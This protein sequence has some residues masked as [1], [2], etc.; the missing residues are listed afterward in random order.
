MKSIV[1][2]LSLCLYNYSGLTQTYDFVCGDVGYETDSGGG[3]FLNVEESGVDITISGMAYDFCNSIS[4]RTGINN[5][6]N[7][8]VIHNYTYT[9]SQ[10]VDFSFI[11][12][13]IN[14]DTET[15]CYND[16]LVFSGDPVFSD[17]YNVLVDA[18]TI[19]PIIPSGMPAYVVIN[20]ENITSFSIAH[21]V[22][23]ITC[24]PGYI[25]ISNMKFTPI[26]SHLNTDELSKKNSFIVNSFVQDQLIL[27][28]DFEMIPEL[29]I[30]DIMGRKMNITYS[31]G[32][33]ILIDVSNLPNGQ[34]FLYYEENYAIKVERFIVSR[35]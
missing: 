3:T 20:Y 23:G 16:L 9:F 8:G 24:N 21:G 29:F 18:D 11:I 22:G 5:G 32:E 15:P 31:I 30:A 1:L 27:G 26:N 4:I 34:Y 25:L 35:Q 19:I 6:V 10:E 28:G 17:P 2:I 7:G 12:T 14:V 33:H 13:D